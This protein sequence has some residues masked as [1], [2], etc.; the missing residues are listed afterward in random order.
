MNKS[1]N[2]PVCKIDADGTKRWYI[3]GNLHR[4]DGPAIEYVDGNKSWWLNG[5]L[6]R[7]DGPAVERAY[8]YKAWYLNDE[9]HREDGPAIEYANGTKEWYLN[10]VEYTKQ[11]YYRELVRRGL[12]TKQEAFVEML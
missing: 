4:E 9:L 2:K 11:E 3:N 5:K 7:E 10:D 6:H 12:C 1:N 8:G